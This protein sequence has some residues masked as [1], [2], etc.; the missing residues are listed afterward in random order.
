MT[1]VPREERASLVSLQWC[2]SP[3]S[4]RCAHPCPLRPASHPAQT[5][6]PQLLAPV[7]MGGSPELPVPR[8]WAPVPGLQ[9][10]HGV[11]GPAGTPESD[12]P[13]APAPSG[14]PGRLTSSG[15]PSASAG[16]PG[17]GGV[18]WGGVRRGGGLRPGLH[19]LRGLGGSESWAI[20]RDCMRRQV[21]R[22]GWGSRQQRRRWR[23]DRP[24][25]P[26]RPPRPSHPRRRRAGDPS[27]CQ[28]HVE[29]RT[30]RHPHPIRNTLP[31]RGSAPW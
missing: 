8:A 12:A 14:R 19:R 23:W 7:W 31:A 2:Q 3:S 16:S 1:E 28:A 24:C 30:H 6:H 26:P 29:P 25:A 4:L 17:R 10:S 22:A 18:R 20:P 15:S 21:G 13:A 9:P 5:F 11:P 27:A